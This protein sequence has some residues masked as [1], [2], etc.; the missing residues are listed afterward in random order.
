MD[1]LMPSK[2]AGATEARTESRWPRM[3]AIDDDEIFFFFSW[4]RFDDGDALQERRESRWPRMELPPVLVVAVLEG[5]VDSGFNRAHCL[6]DLTAP[7]C[8]RRRTPASADT[9]LRTAL[10]LV[11]VRTLSS[12]CLT[13]SFCSCCGHRP[14][15]H[16]PLLSY[17]ALPT[18][19]QIKPEDVQTG[20]TQERTVPGHAGLTSSSTAMTRVEVEE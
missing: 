18:Q 12:F 17:C 14:R 10:C 5:D 15:P 11:K 19:A 6:R 2:K 8:R 13:L 9:A 3:E 4:A 7:F 1:Q 20:D 16:A